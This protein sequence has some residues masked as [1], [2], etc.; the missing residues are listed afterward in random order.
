MAVTIYD[1]ARVAG[2]GVGTV[3][4]VLNNQQAVKDSTRKKVLEAITELNYNPNPVARSMNARRT[5]IIGVIIP[6]LTRP[7]SVE[8]LQ[9]LVKAAMRVD[10]ELMIYNIEEDHQ[11]A[12]FLHNL[13]LRRR[14]DGMIF[15]SLPID[16]KFV[17]GLLKSELPL[18]LVDA[19][20]AAFTSI[21]V[22]NVEGAW[23]AVKSLLNKGHHRIGFINGIT[24][25]SFKFNQAND[26]LIGVHQALT[27]AGIEFNPELMLTSEWTR[28]GGRNAANLLLSLPDPPTAIFAASDLQAVGVLEVARK[29]GIPVPD[30]LSIIGFDGIEL[31]EIL[32]L[33]TV[34]QPM[35]QMGE[36]AVD[37]LLELMES[38]TRAPELIRLNTH[39]I[40]R[41]TTGWY[42]TK[43][44]LAKPLSIS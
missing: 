15:V 42:N 30:K 36:L 34:R 20:S 23:Q 12:S 10:Y 21:V 39:L 13:P 37:K 1:V 9:S 29:H 44:N 5:G 19:Y 14:V 16:E 2:V 24:E 22:N 26:R 31:S 28:E 18:V 43:N 6:F 11:R 25:G 17:P 3:S 41:Q 40:E 7:F 4:R 32:E 8:I 35:Q 38:E 27:E 33:S